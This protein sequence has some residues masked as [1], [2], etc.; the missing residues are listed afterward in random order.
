MVMVSANSVV[1][2][3]FQSFKKQGDLAALCGV[4][5]STAFAWR[6]KGVIPAEHVKALAAHTGI[7]KHRIRPDLF[8]PVEG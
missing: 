2:E 6:L 8:D 5:A 3:I 7:P 4:A 1:E